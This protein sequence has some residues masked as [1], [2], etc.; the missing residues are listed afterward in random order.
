MVE[1]YNKE[2][3]MLIFNY[4]EQ[5]NLQ[6]IRIIA[7]KYELPMYNFRSAKVFH[8]KINPNQYKENNLKIQLSNNITALYWL[9]DIAKLVKENSGDETLINY[10]NSL[11]NIKSKNLVIED[12]SVDY[13][14]NKSKKEIDILKNTVNNYDSDILSIMNIVDN[15]KNQICIGRAFG[16]IKN[17]QMIRKERRKLKNQYSKTS[18]RGWCPC[19]EVVDFI[20][21]N[22]IHIEED[23]KFNTQDGKYKYISN[24][25]VYYDFLHV[26]EFCERISLYNSYKL[27]M[28]ILE[29]YNKYINNKKQI[30][31]INN[32]FGVSE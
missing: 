28:K 6:G 17:I 5:G 3:L 22:K 15:H 23:I 21:E 1:L 13:S 27:L 4:I 29:V 2:D 7:N 11:T 20:E 25:T 30:K 24:I 32:I 26:I 10:I 12:L 8:N 18:K 16:I 9:V 14:I 19:K 31:L